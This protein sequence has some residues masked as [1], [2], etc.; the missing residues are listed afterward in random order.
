MINKNSNA[1]QQLCFLHNSL[2]TTV[3]YV[4][5]GKW[6]GKGVAGT[7]SGKLFL[8]LNLVR[9]KVYFEQEFE[10]GEKWEKQRT[11]CFSY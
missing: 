11:S 2:Y 6:K 3:N 4:S 7:L 8:L 5:P 9:I 1:I 10:R